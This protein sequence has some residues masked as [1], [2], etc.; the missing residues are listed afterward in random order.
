MRNALL[1]FS[2]KD[3]QDYL[4][5]A[6]EFTSRSDNIQRIAND[7]YDLNSEFHA[8]LFKFLTR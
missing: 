1:P 2:K 5:K 3:L 4:R 6:K 7:L 8:K